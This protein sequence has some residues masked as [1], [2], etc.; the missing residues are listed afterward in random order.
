MLTWLF[1]EVS[2]R[3]LGL[4]RAIVGAAALIRSVVAWQVLFRLAEPG[5]MHAPYADWIPDPSVPLALVLIVAWVVSSTLF[6]VGWNVPVTGTL[7]FSSIVM[8]LALDQQTYGNHVYL[9]AWMVLLLTL[10]GAGSGV[11]IGRIDRP[12][13]RWPVLLVMAQLSVVYGFSALTKLNASFLSGRVLAGTLGTGV[14]P[15]PEGLKTPVI[16]SIMATVAVIVE[17]FIAV[18]I[19]RPRFRPAAFVL[20]LGLHTAITLW[21]FGTLQLLVFSLLMLSIYPLFL[22]AE[23]LLVAWDDDCG[24]CRDWIRRFG[25]LDVL[26]LLDPVGKNDPRNSVPAGLVERSMYLTTDAGTHSGFPAVTG[27]LERVV[28][29]LWFAPVF[30]LPG[31]RGLGERWYRWQA[32]RRSCLVGAVPG[33]RRDSTAR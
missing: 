10:A 21:M 12:V 18:F 14:L 22:P 25:R 13:V 9:M 7:L 31:V 16:L 5:V 24:S 23:R 33:T 20:G 3:P 2:P 4:A 1:A 11:N 17:L 29:T 28:P 27:I 32:R 19:W 15:F 26:H 30:R 8:T 6:M